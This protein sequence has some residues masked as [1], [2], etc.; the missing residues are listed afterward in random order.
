MTGVEPASEAWE[1]SILPMNYI[2]SCAAKPHIQVSTLPQRADLCIL[3]TRDHVSWHVIVN[4]SPAGDTWP[5]QDLLRTDLAAM[6]YSIL[7][8]I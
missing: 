7:Y 1:A 8:S 2:R 3:S 6:L 4:A 5:I